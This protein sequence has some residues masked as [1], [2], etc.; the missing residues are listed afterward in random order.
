MLIAGK[1]ELRVELTTALQ[2]PNAIKISVTEL[3]DGDFVLWF[4]VAPEAFQ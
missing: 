2:Y 1:F 4:G 3:L